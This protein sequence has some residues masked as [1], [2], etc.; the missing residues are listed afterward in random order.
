MTLGAEDFQELCIADPSSEENHAKRALQQVL[1]KSRSGST[2]IG[3][4]D[5]CMHGLKSIDQCRR[6]NKFILKQVVMHEANHAQSAGKAS[7]AY[8]KLQAEHAQVQQAR[9]SERLEYE[10]I[11]QELRNQNSALASKNKELEQKSMSKDQ[12]IAQFREHFRQ[13]PGSSHSHGSSSSANNGK[14]H[15]I[16]PPLMQSRQHHPSSDMNRNSS[17]PPPMQAFVKNR[18]MAAAATRN[19]ANK[20]PIL[21]QRVDTYPTDSVHNFTATP[22]HVPNTAGRPSSGGSSSG[23]RV[24]D[25]RSSSSYTFGGNNQRSGGGHS[26]AMVFAKPHRGQSF[27]GFR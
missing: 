21:S 12:Q 24:R 19:A 6:T 22:I 5:L 1:T 4:Q 20:R 8:E 27:Q 14:R 17:P 9:T 11:T 15:R 7:R 23:T 13:T 25:I 26:P 18:A 2:H 3:L 16:D 10:Q